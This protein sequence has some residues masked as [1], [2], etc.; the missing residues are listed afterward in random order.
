MAS[1]EALGLYETI[2]KSGDLTAEVKLHSR[3]SGRLALYLVM[4]L[5]HSILN[6]DPK[7]HLN[8]VL[9]DE[10]KT[11]MHT[12]IGEVLAAGKLQT[13]YEILRKFGAA[14]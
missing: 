13:F 2:L 11:A 5:E 14:G 4:A 3:I 10:D 7:N 1:K 6:D 12:L 8:Q 9:S